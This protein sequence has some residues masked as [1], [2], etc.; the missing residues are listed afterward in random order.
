MTREE[1]AI[2]LKEIQTDD[3][4]E[5]AHVLADEVL[6]K[7]LIALGYDDVATEWDKIKKWY[8]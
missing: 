4:Q 8:S 1:A 3:D 2:R 5:R 7:F 6:C